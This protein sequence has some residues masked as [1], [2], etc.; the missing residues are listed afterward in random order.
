[1]ILD[2]SHETPLAV[3]YALI[4]ATSGVWLRVGLVWFATAA[5]ILGYAALLAHAASTGGLTRAPHHH[6]IAAIALAA[7][8]AVVA[9]QARQARLLRRVRGTAPPR[10]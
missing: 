8:G 5:A 1:L 6:A 9:Y 4:V 2:E 10:D 7:V 3:G